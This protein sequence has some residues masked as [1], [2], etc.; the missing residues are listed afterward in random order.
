LLT[1]TAAA[2][3][4]SAIA[5]A[6]IDQACKVLVLRRIASGGLRVPPRR[7]RLSPRLNV[8]GG[9]LSLPIEAAALVWAVAV[10]GAATVLALASPRPA[11][12]AAVGLGLAIGGAISNLV[13]RMV[14][15]GV[16]D[17]ISVGRWPTFN[18]ADAALV[19]GVALTA[20]SVT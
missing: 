5:T 13:D 7:V 6:G 12:A 18:V 16:I 15:K 19:A 1:T 8:R 2:L 11:S 4:G 17:F 3:L 10:G 9:V 14:R 20:G